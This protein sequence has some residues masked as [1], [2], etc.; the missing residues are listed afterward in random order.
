MKEF[1]KSNLKLTPLVSSKLVA[2]ITAA[3]VAL[4][5]G[6][7]QICAASENG[8]S[9]TSERLLAK[10]VIY[11][12]AVWCGNDNVI[13]NT[14]KS[15]PILFSLS[16]GTQRKIANKNH[17]KAVNCSLDGQWLIAVDINSSRYDKDTSGRED[18]EH[19]VYDY[20]KFALANGGSERFA[21][22]QDG[23]YL[24]PDGSKILFLGKAPQ[25]SIKQLTPRWEFYWSHDW[26]PGT[27]GGAAWMP[28]SKS[29]LLGHRGKFYI[30]RGQE[31][32]PLGMT[33]PKNLVNTFP[34]IGKIKIDNQGNIYVSTT[35]TKSVAMMYQLFKCSINSTQISCI[36]IAGVANGVI[37]FDVVPDGRQLVYVDADHSYLYLVDTATQSTKRMAE[38]VT[39]YPS[40]SPDGKNM[41]FYRESKAKTE[42]AGLDSNDAF[43][44]PLN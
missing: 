33:S 44:L 22:A 38:R 27:G 2:F 1:Q 15:G 29:L 23:G 24:S 14:E 28:D 6:L 37:T 36:K 34:S 25:L 9:A 21:V 26:P 3:L 16:K 19:G 20:L 30:Q 10:N 5:I 7:H 13:L 17:I 12:Q 18:Y 40:I 35:D 11:M 39:G 31:L 4:S 8:A 43:I 32:T 41:V 42:N